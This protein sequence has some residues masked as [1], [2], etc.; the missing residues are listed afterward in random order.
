MA[1]KLKIQISWAT[2]LLEP[3]IILNFLCFEICG[4]TCLCREGVIFG[5]VSFGLE[6]HFLIF[7]NAR[8]SR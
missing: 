6:L 3:R 1:V 2:C 8:S 7:Q 4:D 5:S